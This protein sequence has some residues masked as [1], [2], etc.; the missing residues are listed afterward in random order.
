MKKIW[1]P[2]PPTGYG[3]AAQFLD[4]AIGQYEN[5]TAIQ[6]AQYIST[7][8]NDGYRMKPYLV[9]QIHNSSKGD[10]LGPLYKVNEPT[11]LNK[12]EM[13]DTYLNRVQEGMRQAFQESGGTGY[14]YFADA[15]YNPAG[16]TGTA[17]A[18][19]GT[20]KPKPCIRMSTITILLVMRLLMNQK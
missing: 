13:K 4:M 15:E 20:M 1:K 12:I 6:L 8:A 9:K 17:E 5:Y 2:P 14:R 11:I 7:I 18:F 10:Q 19:T 3:R 16:K